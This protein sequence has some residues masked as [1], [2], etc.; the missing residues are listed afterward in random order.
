MNK[1]RIDT[2]FFSDLV[3][4]FDLSAKFIHFE[5]LE[6]RQD[7]AKCWFIFLICKQDP[8]QIVTK[9]QEIC[10]KFESDFFYR[11]SLTAKSI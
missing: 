6:I 11:T 3:Y 4:L 8:G 2:A 9:L 7:P 10:C 5:K 1:I